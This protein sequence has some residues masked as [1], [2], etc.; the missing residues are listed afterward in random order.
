MSRLVN[1]IQ[2]IVKNLRV[3]KDLESSAPV[4]A[5]KAQKDLHRQ[6]K[7]ATAEMRRDILAVSDNIR[8]DG[9]YICPHCSTLYQAGGAVAMNC[10]EKGIWQCPRCSHVIVR[11]SK[12]P[13]KMEEHAV[14]ILLAVSLSIIFM[15]WLCSAGRLL[16]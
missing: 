5:T 13:M 10:V 6:L 3:A 9:D 15:L 4:L 8:H 14:E 16:P 11:K 7:K 12:W 1:K 2:A